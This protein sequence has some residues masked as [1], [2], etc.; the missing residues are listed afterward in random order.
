MLISK[1]H[2]SDRV[3]V[4][5]IAFVIVH[6]IKRAMKGSQKNSHEARAHKQFIIK[7]IKFFAAHFFEC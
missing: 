6:L 1:L 5:A 7:G 3:F 4:H 2:F